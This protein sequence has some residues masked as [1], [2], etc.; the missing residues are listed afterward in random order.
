MI[1]ELSSIFIYFLV[2]KSWTSLVPLFHVFRTLT[3]DLILFILKLTE[4]TEFTDAS[5]P[6]QTILA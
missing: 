2:L 1:F 4:F 6:S 3:L 5:M